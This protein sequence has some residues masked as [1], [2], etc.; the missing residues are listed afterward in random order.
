MISTL[1]NELRDPFFVR[2]LAANYTWDKEVAR[3]REC[4]HPPMIRG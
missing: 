1:R 3:Y 4:T 2:V